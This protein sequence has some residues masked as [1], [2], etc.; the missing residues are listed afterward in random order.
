MSRTELYLGPSSDETGELE[1]QYHVRLPIFDGPLELLL[2][3]IRKNEVDIYDIPIADITRQY[4]EIL[5]LMESLNLN[6]AGEFLVMAATLIHI[7]SKMLLP[8]PHEDGTSDEP[9]EDPRSELVHRLLEYRRYKEAAHQ[10]HEQ[11]EVR[12]AMWSRPDSAIAELLSTAEED[13]EP[14]V[15]V[16]LFELI[17]AFREVLVRVSQRRDLVFEREVI[18]VEEMIERIASKL[19]SVERTTFVELF[20][21]ALNRATVIVTFLAILE[22]VRLRALR[23]YQQA[24]FATIFVSRNTDAS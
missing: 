22:M 24:E 7:K 3:L 4:L 17:S 15:E 12:S 11:E 14:L 10:L 9:E 1:P 16:D 23:I 21:D 6:L 18:S 8:P 5:E 13:A 20:D 2:H 19:E